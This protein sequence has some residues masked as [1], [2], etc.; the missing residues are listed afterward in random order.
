MKNETAMLVKI[1]EDIVNS[2]VKVALNMLVSDFH[3]G[4]MKELLVFSW[5]SINET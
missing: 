3:Q 5:L 1:L 2:E 4:K